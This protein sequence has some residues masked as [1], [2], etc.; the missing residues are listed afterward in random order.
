MTSG[1]FGIQ[2]V[3]IACTSASIAAAE[4]DSVT[5]L[6]VARTHVGTRVEVGDL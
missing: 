3:A 4:H 5:I 6:K 1:A 2:R